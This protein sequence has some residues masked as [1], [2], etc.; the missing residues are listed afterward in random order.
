MLDK[1]TFIKVY[2]AKAHAN[3]LEAKS[4]LAGELPRA[5]IS[6][7]YYALYQ[8]ANAWIVHKGSAASFDPDWPNAHHEDV[9]KRWRG[10]LHDIHEDHGIESDFDGDKLYGKL[11]SLRVRVDYKPKSEPTMDD[12]ETA[13]FDSD[14]TVGWLLAAL[15]KAGK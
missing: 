15:K 12:A 3:L 5:A 13:V 11:K 10:I 2:T 4:C 7:A 8:A 6:R 1:A 14:R 9:E